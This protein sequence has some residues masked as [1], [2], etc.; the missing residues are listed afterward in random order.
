M[1][2]GVTIKL[3]PPWFHHR[4][5]DNTLQLTVWHTYLYALA[6]GIS[7]ATLFYSHPIL[8][9]IA[10]SFHTTDLQVSNVPA[11][12]SLGDATGLLF[13]L[14]L[15]DYFPRRRF[16]LTLLS[17]TIIFWTGLCFTRSLVVFQILTYLSAVTSSIIQIFQVLVAEKAPPE[18]KARYISTVTIGPNF[19]ILIARILSGV[20]A[21]YL[22]WRSV[23]VVA[24]I[25]QLTM[26]VLLWM[27]MPDYYALN[28]ITVKELIKRYPKIVVDVLRCY[29]YPALVQVG[30]ITA[31]SAFTVASFWTTITFLL[32]SRYHFSTVAIG[33]FGLIGIATMS[34]AQIY[35]RF[36]I[37]PIDNPLVSAAAGKAVSVVGVAIGLLGTRYILALVAQALLLD[38]GL[39]IVQTSN[40]MRLSEIDKEKG[41]SVNTAFV[42]MQ[43]CGMLMGTKI[44]NLVYARAGWMASGGV[45]LGALGLAYVVILAR[46]LNETGWV[47]WS[48]G[49]RKELIQRDEEYGTGKAREEERE[50]L[51]LLKDRPVMARTSSV[52][53][54]QHDPRFRKEGHMML[55]KARLDSVAT[56][57]HSQICPTF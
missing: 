34:L 49:W 45:S 5:G 54:C 20:I 53:S 15:A 30:C 17:L 33:L 21:N 37:Q 22:P 13:L 48:G 44:G 9:L 14:P 18:Q 19:G 7:T 41:N 28:Q 11:L 23:Y 12:A 29:A 42:V 10:A 25:L 36:I 39:V 43:Y 46:G 24:L 55:C 35:R 51:P 2:F 50:R 4:S 31:L 6:G 32:S 57:V 47:G 52:R 40:R 26:L 1:S 8:N 27:Y 16:V 38:A 56:N 3:L